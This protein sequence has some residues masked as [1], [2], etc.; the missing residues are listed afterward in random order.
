M[1][2]RP[3]PPPPPLIGYGGG[4]DYGEEDDGNPEEEDYNNVYDYNH[5]NEEEDS[6]S[7]TDVVAAAAQQY[8]AALQSQ[9][10]S[11]PATDFTRRAQ[12]HAQMQ[13]LCQTEILR[14]G[15]PPVPPRGGDQRMGSPYIRGGGGGVRRTRGR[16]W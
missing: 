13:N 15:A 6:S 14:Q 11:I 12:L 3:P 8:Y 10:E 9:L 5:G 2:M 1:M 4:F 16:R 7:P